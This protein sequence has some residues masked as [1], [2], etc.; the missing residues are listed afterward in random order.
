VSFIPLYQLVKE[1]IHTDFLRTRTESDNARLPSER[2]LQLHYKVSRPTISKALTALAAEGLLVKMQGSGSYAVTPPEDTAAFSRPRRIGFVAP[3]TGEALV[4]NVFRGIDRAAH[5]RNFCVLMGSAGNNVEREE[6]AVRQQL[7][8]GAQGLVVYPVPRTE[9]EHNADYLRKA[10]LEVPVVL[11]D[12]STPEQGHTQVI[13]DNRRAGYAM[14][15]WLIHRGHR[16]IGVLFHAE[17]IRHAPLANRLQGYQDAL[18]LNGIAFSPE[19]VRRFQPT[20]DHVFAAHL[21]TWLSLPQPPTAIITSEDMIALE[22]IEQ[23]QARGLRV[24]DDLCVVGFDNR[25]AGRRFRP[26]CA[27]TH[28]NFEHMGE[29]ACHALL[30]RIEMPDI[31]PHTYLLDVPLMIRRHVESLPSV[32]VTHAVVVRQEPAL[33]R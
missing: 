16:H 26:L 25:E 32:A 12:T 6:Q 5:R 14:T 9:A 4:Q 22:L 2:E 29:I 31:P 30:D 10:A 1:R 8:S 28:P 11:V 15:D 20:G 27:T 33:V 19:M 13:F 3:V 7:D 23:I 24:P 18:R 17:T 21:D